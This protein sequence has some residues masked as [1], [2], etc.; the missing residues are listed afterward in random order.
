MPFLIEGSLLSV[1]GIIIIY[2]K[3]LSFFSQHGKNKTANICK[4]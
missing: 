1:G 3:P 4:M 2:T